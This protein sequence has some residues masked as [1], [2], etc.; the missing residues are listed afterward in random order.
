MNSDAGSA[1]GDD[2]YMCCGKET[3]RERER[4][5]E[6]GQKTGPVYRT[7]KHTMKRVMETFVIDQSV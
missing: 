3:K 4:E 6:E 5:R 1:R 2:I 7:R